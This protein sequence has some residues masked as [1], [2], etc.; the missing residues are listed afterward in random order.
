MTTGKSQ[1]MSVAEQDEQNM[2]KAIAD[3][4]HQEVGVIETGD[5]RFGPATGNYYNNKDWAMTYAPARAQE[6]L[7]NP[8]PEYR[9]RLANQPAFMKPS[10]AGHYLPALITILHAVPM[11][12]EAMLLRDHTLPD[13]GSGNEWWDGI[14][15]QAPRIVELDHT[16]Q[17]DLDWEE[18][19]FETQRLMAF[20]DRTE[21]AYGSTDVLAH[22]EGLDRHI[23]VEKSFLEVWQRTILRACPESE[24]A[25]IFDSSAVV[26]NETK[27]FLLLELRN[28]NDNPDRPYSL[29][30]AFD[31]ALWSGYS[32]EDPDEVYL[33]KISD[34]FIIRVEGHHLS[35]SGLGIKIPSVWYPDRYL[36]ESIGVTR[37][38]R[39]GKEQKKRE[40]EQI[41]ATQAKLT[42]L[43]GRVDDIDARKLLSISKSYLLAHGNREAAQELQA[44]ADRVTLKFN[45]MAFRPW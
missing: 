44:V 40:I 21:R 25:S 2:Q 43:Q 5:T 34:V 22:M 27:D 17:E 42:T 20:L 3:S 6:I 36:K 24:L 14:S 4:M 19:I 23:D 31:D 35:N 29:Y 37:G 33:D 10:P 38:M 39:L 1:Q 41:E 32:A 13:Y 7:Q 26:G 8:E 12:R 11:A 30:D 45:G 28:A 18:L 9:K 16:A 15:I